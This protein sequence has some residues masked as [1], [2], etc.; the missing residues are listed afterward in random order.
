MATH[1]PRRA[2][3]VLSELVERLEFRDRLR[4]H[5]VWTVWE[6]VVGEILAA[7]AE[8]IRIEDGKLVVRVAN[9]AW[10]QELQFL[11]EEIRARLN[12]RLGSRVVRNIYLVLGGVRR[13][14]PESDQ[15]E[16]HAVDEEAIAALV[17]KIGRPDLE[18]ALRRV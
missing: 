8:P 2:G 12:E 4:E 13:G 3:G 11:K 14:R 9:S 1:S 17:P 5:R 6:E 15:R 7:R 16:V 10:M 18:A